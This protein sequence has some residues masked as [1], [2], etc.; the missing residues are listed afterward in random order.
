MDTLKKK[1]AFENLEIKYEKKRR[2]TQDPVLIPVEPIFFFS[3]R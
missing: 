2:N 1:R 3:L